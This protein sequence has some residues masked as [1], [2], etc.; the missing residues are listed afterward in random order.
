MVK[1][2]TNMLTQAECYSELDR[3]YYKS[4]NTHVY[5]SYVLCLPLLFITLLVMVV[6]SLKTSITTKLSNSANHPNV[7]GLVLTGIFYHLFFL[8]MDA[9]AVYNMLVD[10]EL[11]DL[12]N[13]NAH[14]RFNFFAT[15][16]TLSFNLFITMTL[17]LCSAYLHSK[18]ICGRNKGDCCLFRHIF[19]RVFSPLFYVI[20]GDFDME[21]F[22]RKV[23]DSH[24]NDSAASKLK[25]Q[26]ITWIVC[27]MLLSPVFSLASHIGYIFAAWLTEPSKATSVALLFLGVSIYMF[28]MLRQCYIANKV[29]EGMQNC[30]NWCLVCYPFWQWIKC[31]LNCF[32]LCC[33]NKTCPKFTSKVRFNH[34][35]EESRKVNSFFD[36]QAFCVTFAW[37]WPLAGTVAFLVSAFYELPIASYLL[38][39]YLLN[40]FQVF[41]VMITLLITYKILQITEPEIRTFM[42]SMKRAYQGRARRP[43]SRRLVQMDEDDVE[44]TG[45]L[46]GELVEVVIHELQKSADL[47]FVTHHQQHTRTTT[48]RAS[49]SQRVARS[50]SPNEIDEGTQL[51]TTRLEKSV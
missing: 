11:G 36:T 43:R 32:Y 9:V 50:H 4:V 41:V 48:A 31:S 26:H 29:V 46:V 44:A 37:G 5:L 19:P 35:N 8:A 42:R 30:S 38:P 18:H 45:A 1:L 6:R 49:M 2:G 51:L 25:R 22:W 33:F 28:L 39:I 10:R 7:A 13:A 47:P 40:A 17:L 3:N 16:I 24:Q 14:E 23:L 15:W 27:F 34:L 12:P 21:D 20:F